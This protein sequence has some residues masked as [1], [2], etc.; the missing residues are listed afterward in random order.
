[1]QKLKIRDF[2]QKNRKTI[3]S[4]F[5]IFFFYIIASIIAERI[6]GIGHIG[7]LAPADPLEWNEILIQMPITILI[8]LIISIISAFY[9][10]IA[11]KI[12]DKKWEDIR[13]KNEEE[14]KEE[15]KKHFR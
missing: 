1:M 15:N 8:A 2:L 10:T 5:F 6:V 4:C 12:D 11:Q 9:L 14:N 7:Y 13:K 3:K